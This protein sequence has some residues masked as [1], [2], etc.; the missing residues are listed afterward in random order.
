M[1]ATG[2][3]SALG[4][5]DYDH[6]LADWVQQNRCDGSQCCGQAALKAAARACKEALSATENVAI[7][8]DFTGLN[9]VLM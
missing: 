8:V 5:D 9:C 2:G 3:D 1:V 6:A 7:D 4:G